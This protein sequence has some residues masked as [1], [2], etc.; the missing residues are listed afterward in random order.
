MKKIAIFVCVFVF[1]HLFCN[2]Q[3]DGFFR[4]GSDNYDNRDGGISNET[5]GQNN[6]FGPAAPTDIVPL[7]SGLIIL[8]TAGAGYVMM[9]RRRPNNMK[10]IFSIISVL[11]V[12]LGLT[13]CKKKTEDFAN[14]QN[15]AHIILNVDGDSKVDVNTGT[16]V[17]EFKAGDVIYVGNNNKYVGTL[18]HNGSRF[19]GNITNATEG[20][21]LYFYFMGNQTPLATLEAGTTEKC[22]FKIND[23]T[24]G[25]PVISFAQ[26]TANY[27]SSVTSYSASL[28]NRCA[29]VKFTP[30]VGRE[31]ANGTIKLLGMKNKITL[32]FNKPGNSDKGIYP[33]IDSNDGGEIK[34]YKKNNTEFWAILLLNV[35]ASEAS[36][37]A[38]GCLRKT[39]ISV[40]AI[41]ANAFLTSGIVIDFDDA[42]EAAFATSEN[43]TYIYFATGNL[44]CSKTG[45][46]WDDGYSWSF[47]D[48][49][50][51]IDF[52][53]A[54]DVGEN[55]VKT[56]KI[57]HFGWGASGYNKNAGIAN[58]ANYVDPYALNYKPNST[59]K[60]IT[61]GDKRN[62][63]H[64]GPSW[65]ADPD[66][67]NYNTAGV[68]I[69]GSNFDWGVYHS[70]GGASG[71]GIK[72]G[73]VYS[74]YSW[75]LFTKAEIAYILGPND[76]T[77]PV[78]GK[79]CRY[80][81]TIGEVENA[82][83][84]KVR[85]TDASNGSGF[86][87][88]GLII[89]PDVYEHPDPTVSPFVSYPVNINNLKC[90]FTSNTY[91]IAQWEAMEAKGAI[92]LPA[93]GC[94]DGN[95][96]DGINTQCY[97]W[98]S[99]YNGYSKDGD[100]PAEYAKNLRVGDDSMV[101]DS[102][103]QRSRGNSVRLVRDAMAPVPTSSK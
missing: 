62:P 52:S 77:V 26:S 87:L 93:A 11:V 59:T 1:A 99:T 37:K 10:K 40:P 24:G 3:S 27:S 74:P 91:S 60:E 15:T 51:E 95:K 69:A 14:T 33:Y 21:P 13:Q 85:L 63:Y 50:Y 23:Q 80:S 94:H 9:K 2:A 56:N 71:L 75:R 101:T 34:L 32:E 61:T 12:I 5:F 65:T 100:N 28:S 103:T 89:F 48:S 42:P 57:S 78:P 76:G 55:Y 18:T 45:T 43:D 83:F 30:E 73:D 92:F 102:R 47:M 4:G 70:A 54:Y 39:G 46:N 88:N 79:N 17:V 25:L 49:Q 84:V 22:S 53:N 90:S 16:G 98:T 64:Y 72:D 66:P 38:F 8:M 67:G 7:G 29:L 81:S 68:D 35:S 31:I 41:T 20:M 6:T 19:E 96:I 58:P 82:R 97:Y 44:R 36:A 86:G